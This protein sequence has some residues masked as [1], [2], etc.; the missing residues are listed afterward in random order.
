METRSLLAGDLTAGLQVEAS[1][2]LLQVLWCCRTAG[3]DTGASLQG[4]LQAGPG[5][6]SYCPARPGGRSTAGQRNRFRALQPPGIRAAD[7]Q[8]VP[9][10]GPGHTAELQHT[11]RET[12]L[13][14][15]MAAAG[16]TGPH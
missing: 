14:C 8:S 16:Q 11:V 7:R 6:R 9:G 2:A 13:Q 1:R 15:G 10:R 4:G 12:V 3:R 5:E